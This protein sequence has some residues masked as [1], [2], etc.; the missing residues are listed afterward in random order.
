MLICENSNS[1]HINANGVRG[2]AAGTIGQLDTLLPL[3][4][5]AYSHIAKDERKKLDSKSHKLILLGYADNRKAYR[6]YDLQ[7]QRVIHSHDVIFQETVASYKQNE[8][9]NESTPYVRIDASEDEST[10]EADVP[11]TENEETV[12]PNN[13]TQE[14]E[15]ETEQE[16]ESTVRHSTR[17]TRRPDRYRVW[18]NQASYIK[19]PETVDEALTCSNHEKWKKAMDEEYSSLMSNDVWELV[20]LPK[21]ERVVSSKWIFKCKIGATGNIDRYKARLVAQGYSQRPGVDYKETFSPVVRFESLRMIA[22]LAAQTNLQLHQMD[23]KTAFLNGELK[24]TVYMKQPEGYEEKAKEDLVCKLKRSIYGLKQSPRCWNHTLDSQLKKMGFAQSNSDPCLYISITGEPF[25][26]AVYVDDILLAGRSIQRI[27]EVKNELRSQ[28]NVKDMGSVEYFLGVKVQQDLEKG[29]VWMGQTSY[30]ESILH[31]FGMADSKSVRSPVNP[32][33]KLSKATDESILF[34]SEK[35]QS[36]VGKLLFLAT[37]TRPDIAFA[38]SNVAKYTSNPTEQHWKAVKHIF[39]Y[40]VGTINYGLLYTTEELLKCLGYSDSDWAGDLDNRKSTSGYGFLVGGALV[41]WRS[42][43]QTCVALSTSEAEY[44]AL[45]STAQEAVWIRQLLSE[46]KRESL[47]TIL[48]YEDNQ[49]AICLSKNPQYHGRSK[50]IDIKY[51]YIRDQVK[52]GVIDVQYCKTED[53]IADMMTKG[54]HGDQFEKL[55]R[56]AGVMTI[57]KT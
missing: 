20:K 12:P 47:Q 45:S 2:D 9:E 39:R 11:N 26:I 3:C 43:K 19:E 44:M 4:T 54:L 29:T 27:N 22:A 13:E 52:D 17:V 34:D 46:I 49:S 21:D 25:I 28:F 42:C 8:S 5:L 16:P 33:I 41:S 7:K 30:T 55:R 10:T 40:L 56:M 36:A 37:R 53:M 1:S 6:L 57:N 32:S 14:E 51:H 38:V 35:Y 23:V 15:N 24:E 48:V 50:H 18:I 31:Q